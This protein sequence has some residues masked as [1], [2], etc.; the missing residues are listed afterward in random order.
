MATLGPVPTKDIAAATG[1]FSLTRQLGGSIGVAILTTLLAQ[2]EAFHRTVLIEKLSYSDPKVVE[3]V[4][5][6]T[7]GFAR[8]VD[9]AVAHDRAL[10]VIDGSV[11]VQAAVISFNDTFWITAVLFVVALPLVLL[12]GK[13]PSGVKVSAGH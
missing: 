1:F 3:R 7:S 13:P 6:L 8:S 9:P 10:R 2:R 12:L 11:N 4:A 5:T